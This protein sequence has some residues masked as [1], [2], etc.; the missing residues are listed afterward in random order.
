MDRDDRGATSVEYALIAVSI[1]AAIVVMV[2]A[3]G[4][5]LLELWS[6]DF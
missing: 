5:D 3:V 2:V 1:A 4:Q 6:I